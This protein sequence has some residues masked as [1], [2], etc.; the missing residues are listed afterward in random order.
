LFTLFNIDANK[1]PEL[2][3]LL[4]Q[5]STLIDLDPN[6]SAIL[7]EQAIPLALPF[8]DFALLSTLYSSLGS[9]NVVLHNPAAVRNYDA[10][11]DM[12]ENSYR[13]D[14]KV[15]AL[16][17]LGR[18]FLVFGEVNTSL[19]YGEKALQLA[20]ELDLVNKFPK[21]LLSLG[22][23][24]ANTRQYE[25]Y[26]AMSREAA[27]CA[28]SISDRRFHGHALNNWA[29]G[30][31]SQF[32]ALKEE[33]GVSHTELLDEAIERARMSL[34][35]VRQNG[36]IRLE[37]LAAETLAHAMEHKGIYVEAIA[38]L[39]D[40]LRRLQNHGFV[41]EIL[42][43]RMRRG[44]LLFRLG[45]VQDG[46]DELTATHLAALKLGNYPHLADLLKDL[47]EANET[48][49]NLSTA[50]A[51]MREYHT[52]VLKQ[53]DHRSQISAQIYAA[54]MDLE[55]AQKEVEAHKNRVSQ[56]E[57][58]NRS[59]SVQANEDP[60]TSLPNR[61]ALEE[62]MALRLKAA[63][64][65]FVFI[66]CDIDFFKKVNDN[67]SHLIGDDVLRQIGTLLTG[68]LRSNDMAARIGGEEFALV[69]D[70]CN[71]EK[72]IEACNR[73]RKIVEKFQWKNIAENLQITMSFG[74]TSFQEGD[75]LK[76]LMTRADDALYRSKRNGRNRAERA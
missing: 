68:C 72:L 53:M 13:P 22:L 37:L 47:C 28:A 49:G 66:M 39:E 11:L 19:E 45:R 38:H 51:C 10:A 64:I 62:S 16:H 65:D 55:R 57:N 63:K 1:F 3:H 44:A 18:T 30:L 17:G 27:E 34:L 20:R 25:R 15:D 32:L 6:A 23:V 12:A 46:I 73:I 9:C 26:I 56:L 36:L 7:L 69:L 31:T 4:D 2:S 74:V 14:L 58:F 70:H 24:F 50:L 33:S 29:D 42:D 8:N 67:F 48:I 35:L 40:T 75:T 61:R 21:I 59:L 43:I 54:K 5:I 76:S 71:A 52:V 41:K 60:L